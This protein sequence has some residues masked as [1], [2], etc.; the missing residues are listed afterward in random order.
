MCL[1]VPGRLLERRDVAGVAA[2]VVDIGGTLVEV[3]LTLVPEA[4]PGD[5]VLVHAGVAI[6]RLDEQ[7]AAETLAL[8]AEL[9]Q[10]EGDANDEPDGADHR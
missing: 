10:R 1:A 6:R 5:H 7:A 8:L 4:E 2:G 3:A 9:D